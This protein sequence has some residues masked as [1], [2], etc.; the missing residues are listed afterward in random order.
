MTKEEI[1]NYVMDTPDNTNRR[2]LSDML[3]EFTSSS[4][5]GGIF[6]FEIDDY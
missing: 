3:D 6:T 2:V 4:G 1:L 5:G